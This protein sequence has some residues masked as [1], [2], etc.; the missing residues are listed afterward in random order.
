MASP[1]S[2]RSGTPPRDEDYRAHA[3]FR[4]SQSPSGIGAA[5]IESSFDGA[6]HIWTC[7]VSDGDE[8]HYIRVLGPELGPFPDVPPEAVEQGIE[9]F[10]ATLPAQH[11]IRHLLNGNPLHMDRERNVTD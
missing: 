2:D 10:A 1:H 8:W 7:V 4:A 11:R 9:R 3:E 5:V 6:E